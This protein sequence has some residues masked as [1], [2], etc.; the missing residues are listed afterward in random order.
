MKF[1]LKP[2]DSLQLFDIF[3][4]SSLNYGSPIWGFTK[5]KELERLH[6]KFL[7]SLHGVK[8]S[9]SN[10]DIYIELGRYPLFVA[11]VEDTATMSS[12]RY[13]ENY[14]SYFVQT[15]GSRPY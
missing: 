1:D 14:V 2:N 9:T 3:I 15:K 5:S 12:I 10:A 8:A 11:F 7:K 6:L 4:S 13:F